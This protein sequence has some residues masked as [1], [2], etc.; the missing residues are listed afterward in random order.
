MNGFEKRLARLSGRVSR[1]AWLQLQGMRI[2]RNSPTCWRTLRDGALLDR[3][4]ERAAQR[5]FDNR[6]DKN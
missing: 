6:E 4:I 2:T 5:F 3:D 1:E